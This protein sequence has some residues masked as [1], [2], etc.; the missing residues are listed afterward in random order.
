MLKENWAL[1]KL[2]KNT[3]GTLEFQGYFIQILYRSFVPACF[4]H[5]L[6]R[7]RVSLRAHPPR[8]SYLPRD[9]AELGYLKQ[10]CVSWKSSLLS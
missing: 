9:D 4:I 7:S 10:A 5:L 8:A 3:P 6:S 1:V 2:M